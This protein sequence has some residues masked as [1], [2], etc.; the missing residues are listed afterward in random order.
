MIIFRIAYS[1]IH[2]QQSADSL[3]KLLSQI[4]DYQTKV[5]ALHQLA[6]FFL[7]RDITKSLDYGKQALEVATKYN[8][9]FGTIQAYTHLGNLYSQ[10]G[11]YSEATQ[12]L[13]KA[14]QIADEYNY[15][16][17][18]QKVLNSIGLLY[19]SQKN[20]TKAIQNFRQSLQIA[21]QLKDKVA[22]A[23]AENFIGSC[24]Y[25]MGEYETALQYY[26]NALSTR[27]ML[28]DEL[29]VAKVLN[30]IGLIYKRQGKYAEALAN[31]EHTLKVQEKIGS[32]TG[33]AIVLDNIGDTYLLLNDLEKA[34][35]FHQRGF[36]LAQ[37]VQNK[38]LLLDAYQSLANTFAAKKDFEQAYYYEHQF[39]LLQDSL[40]STEIQKR[41]AD[42]QIAQ[43]LAQKEKELELSMQKSKLKEMQLA[44]NQ[45]F[46]LFISIVLLLVIFLGLQIYWRYKHNKETTQ[47]LQEALTILQLRTQEVQQ[48]AQ[49]IQQQNL[50]ITENHEK[51]TDSILYA[52]RIQDAMLLTE[53]EIHKIYPEMFVLYLPKDIVSGDFY[54]LDAQK[55][56]K[57][58]L[59][60]L[61]LIVADC[62][63]HGVPG[64]FMT[65]LG[66]SFLNNIIK[67]RKIEQPA[68]ILKE[69]DK[70]ITL[71][72]QQKT[73]HNLGDKHD[74]MDVAIMQWEVYANQIHF[75]GAKRPLYLFRNEQLII[76]KGDKK[77]IGGDKPA[78]QISEPFL[79][80]TIQVLPKDVIYLFSDGYADQFGDKPNVKYTL[81]RFKEQL[82][83]ICSQ[84]MNIQ[85]RQLLENL[86]LWQ[87]EQR[88]TDDILVIGLQI[89]T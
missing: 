9:H 8:Y 48:Q 1:Q 47:K 13:L 53:Q 74:G 85:K 77:A 38:E 17:Q 84:P 14:I 19:R 5:L 88:Q 34:L 43:T 44:Q 20:Y 10:I 2:T 54:W 24:Y 16:Q 67:E 87:G 12:Y 23:D 81:K 36:Q 46:T 58:K 33:L 26:N 82:F 42:E 21:E 15:Q 78:Q 70:Q 49:E 41:L 32:A 35:A 55:D 60:K 66:Q 27:K 80:E 57:G 63:G 73:T 18:K 83:S 62:T 51:L 4:T 79:Q 72:L 52:K 65:L 61:L 45:Y 75:A 25:L 59:E 64:A 76:Y 71:I 68:L 69:L 86:H 11:K 89:K 56:A 6:T 40:I 30:N 22:I 39:V 7:E 3:A 31:F 37:K 50:I 28:K 29:G